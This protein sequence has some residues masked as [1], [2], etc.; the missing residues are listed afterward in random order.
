[1]QRSETR[2]RSRSES[3]QK[4]LNDPRLSASLTDIA[5]DGRK[6]PARLEFERKVKR[7]PLTN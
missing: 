2:E 7:Y 3:V 6:S 5:K 1:M 4:A